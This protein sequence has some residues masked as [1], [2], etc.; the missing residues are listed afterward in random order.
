MGRSERPRVERRPR[1]HYNSRVMKSIE[2]QAT[3]RDKFGNKASRRLRRQGSVPCALYGGGETT[4]FSVVALDIR[5]L[6]YTPHS[7]IVEL[8]FGD[9]KELAVLREV[10]YHPV[11]EQILHMDFYRVIEGKPVEIDIPIQI[12]GTSEGVR[13][14]GT[15]NI[16]RRKIHVRG[17]MET[18]PDELYLDVS[19]MQLNDTIFV[20]D[21]EFEGLQLITPP[22]AAVCSVKMTRMATALDDEDDEDLDD[23]DLEGEEGEE[24]EEGAEG[25]ED[26]SADE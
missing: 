23:E 7:Y 3:K 9:R 8:D 26:T 13:Q 16:E 1:K 18:L 11:R 12:T 6:I 24:G 22:T 20:G 21:L 17:M 5:K 19:D 15:L 4:H 14:G 25:E 10:Q 2:V